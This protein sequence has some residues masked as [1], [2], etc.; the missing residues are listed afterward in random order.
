MSVVYIAIFA[1]LIAL[2][3]LP[4][5]L[6]KSNDNRLKALKDILSELK[7]KH[8]DR[9]EQLLA[10]H[11]RRVDYGAEVDVSFNRLLRELKE[12]AKE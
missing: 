11:N 1:V 5:L 4:H 12:L 3:I 2:P 6:F 7:N 10:Q 9:A 8:Q